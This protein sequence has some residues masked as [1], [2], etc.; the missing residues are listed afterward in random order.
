V[1]AQ[2]LVQPLFFLVRQCFLQFLVVLFR[3]ICS[4]GFEVARVPRCKK[5]KKSVMHSK[6]IDLSTYLP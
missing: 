6:G 1:L 3:E 4:D 5:K 2:L